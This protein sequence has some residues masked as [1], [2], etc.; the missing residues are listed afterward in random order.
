MLILLESSVADS[1]QI[2]LRAG[3]SSLHTSV[4]RL[5]ANTQE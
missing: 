5:S 2:R 4:S 1:M 3:K